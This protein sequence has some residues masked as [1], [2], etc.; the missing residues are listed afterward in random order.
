[1]LYNI[2]IDDIAA[3]QSTYQFGLLILEYADDNNG[4]IY[5]INE[6]I[7][8]RIRMLK[9][10]ARAVSDKTL[11]TKIMEEIESHYHN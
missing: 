2:K 8:E 7:Y 3:L 6:Y 10:D 9:G 5:D 1:M 4:M 11:R